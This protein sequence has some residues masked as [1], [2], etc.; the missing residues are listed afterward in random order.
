[1]K[2][3]ITQHKEL[4]LPKRQTVAPQGNRGARYTNEPGECYQMDWGFI[5]VDNGDGTESRIACFAMVCH[6]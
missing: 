6:Y 2:A 1:M 3:Y 5:N 4:V